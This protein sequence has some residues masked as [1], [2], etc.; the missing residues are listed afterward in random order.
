MTMIRYKSLE[1]PTSCELLQ[2][3]NVGGRQRACPRYNSA[4]REHT[5]L[6]QTAEHRNKS[7]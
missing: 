7:T 4:Q 6:D 1:S 3:C 2:Q 5:E